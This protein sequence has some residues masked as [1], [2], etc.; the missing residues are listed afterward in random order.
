MSPE[1]ISR[2]LQSPGGGQLVTNVGFVFGMIL[3]GLYV[4]FVEILPH[5]GFMLGECD[6][7]GLHEVG[8]PWGVVAM[9]GLLVAPKVLGADRVVSFFDRILPGGKK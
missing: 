3:G 5:V 4:V 8:V 2:A 1:R 6:C 9:V 7:E